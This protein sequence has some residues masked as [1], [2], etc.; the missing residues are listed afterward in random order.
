MCGEQQSSRRSNQNQPRIVTLPQAGYD[1]AR[2]RGE[3]FI[4]IP[5]EVRCFVIVIDNFRS[6]PHPNHAFLL[7]I[8]LFPVQ[9]LAKKKS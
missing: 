6:G 8:M 3:A 9:R 5:T 1:L 2:L 7:S 4:G